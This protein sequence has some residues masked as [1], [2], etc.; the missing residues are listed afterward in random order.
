[1]RDR[2]EW[3]TGKTGRPRMLRARGE[4]EWETRNLETG[5]TRETGE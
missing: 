1:M 5:E 2:G 4:I 3:E